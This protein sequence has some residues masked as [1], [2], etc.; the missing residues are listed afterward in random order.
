[1]ARRNSRPETSV[2]NSRESRASLA[3]SPHRGFSSLSLSLSLS[4]LNL[5]VLLAGS[6]LASS[7]REKEIHSDAER[8]P[9]NLLLVPSVAVPFCFTTVACQVPFSPLGRMF[10]RW[11]RGHS[12]DWAQCCLPDRKNPIRQRSHFSA[13]RIL[14]RLISPDR[15]FVRCLTAACRSFG[16]HDFYLAIGRL[17][18]VLTGSE[19]SAEGIFRDR[20]ARRYSDTIASRTSRSVFRDYSPFEGTF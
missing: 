19:K 5:L 10:I 18:E 14:L 13:N 9:V 6:V 16:T 2:V 15:H 11:P 12:R 17:G 20:S 3:G 1:V 7:P 4:L 8:D